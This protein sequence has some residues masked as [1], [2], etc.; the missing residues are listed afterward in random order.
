MF[1]EVFTQCM[2]TQR[3]IKVKMINKT[4]SK[5]A[6]LWTI[7]KYDKVY[8]EQGGEQSGLNGYL[9]HFKQFGDY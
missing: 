6:N 4:C 7:Q 9:P 3:G 1:L 2:E 8:Q 5:G